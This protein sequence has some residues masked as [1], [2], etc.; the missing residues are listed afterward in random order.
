M[1]VGAISVVVEPQNGNR[2]RATAS[3]PVVDANGQPVSGATVTGTWTLGGSSIGGG[4]GSTNGSGVA[5]INS[6]KQRV[7]GSPIWRFTVTDVSLT[8]FTYVPSTDDFG[9]T[10]QP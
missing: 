1:H 10:P 7:S 3:V 9:E 5:S 4:S 8:G 6:S 2:W